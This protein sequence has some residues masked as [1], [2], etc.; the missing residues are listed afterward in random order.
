M[1]ESFMA[2][3]SLTLKQGNSNKILNLVSL[4]RSTKAIKLACSGLKCSSFSTDI[5]KGGNA[6]AIQ[7]RVR[8]VKALKLEKERNEAREA[9]LSKRAEFK[10]AQEAELARIDTYNKSPEGIAKLKGA[11]ELKNTAIKEKH[12]QKIKKIQIIGGFFVIALLGIAAWI[13][14]WSK[15][16]KEAAQLKKKAKLKKKEQDFALA[17]ERARVAKEEEQE[18]LRRVEVADQAREK[19]AQDAEIANYTSKVDGQ[20]PAL[21]RSHGEYMILK[22]IDASQIIQ[23]TA[24]LLSNNHGTLVSPSQVLKSSK[25]TI[26]LTRQHPDLDADTLV[27]LVL[28]NSATHKHTTKIM[29]KVGAGLAV[30]AGIALG[31]FG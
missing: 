28:N 19:S 21:M 10:A 16:Q 4:K 2:G 29:K 30:G 7:N 24:I 23:S 12:D 3:S 31:S 5:D 8:E 17:K 20:I 26:D 27:M 6:N 1:A 22:G 18:A 9:E 14:P 25:Y 13:T 15:K 11:M